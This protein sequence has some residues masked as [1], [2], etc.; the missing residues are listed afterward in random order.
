LIPNVPWNGCSHLLQVTNYLN[1]SLLNLETPQALALAEEERM[2]ISNLEVPLSLSNDKESNH[3]SPQT[4]LDPSRDPSYSDVSIT[5]STHTPFLPIKKRGTSTQLAQ[6]RAG[7]QFNR[8]SR[9][10]RALDYMRYHLTFSGSICRKFTPSR[11]GPSAHYN[12]IVARRS[13][14]ASNTRNSFKATS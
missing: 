4:R 1:E 11:P 9:Y 14:L 13:S 7:K 8:L 2:R 6:D 5:P 10:I 3:P 12:V